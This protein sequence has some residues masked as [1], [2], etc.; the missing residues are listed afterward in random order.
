M[1]SV[2]TKLGTRAKHNTQSVVVPVGLV[3]YQKLTEYLLG[4]HE[5][6]EQLIVMVLADPDCPRERRPYNK[7]VAVVVVNLICFALILF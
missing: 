6:P 7:F 4:A 2:L 1:H 5:N 3:Q